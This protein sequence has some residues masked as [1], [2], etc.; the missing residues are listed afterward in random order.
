MTLLG[1]A[2]AWPLAARAQQAAMPVIGVLSSRSLADAASEVVA[3]RRRLDDGPLI[4]LW[5]QT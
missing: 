5:R 1:S 2:A 4:S 3:F